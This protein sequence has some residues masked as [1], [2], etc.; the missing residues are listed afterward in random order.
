[1]KDNSVVSFGEGKYGRLGHGDESNQLIPKTIA[2]NN[3]QTKKTCSAGEVAQN[4]RM[5]AIDAKYAVEFCHD[6]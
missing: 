3:S 2:F 5:T 6:C 4:T 1:M